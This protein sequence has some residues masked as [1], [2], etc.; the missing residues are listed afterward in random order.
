MLADAALNFAVGLPLFAPELVH[1]G[2]PYAVLHL[3]VGLP[4]IAPE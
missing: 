3:A 4:L 1:H 2:Q